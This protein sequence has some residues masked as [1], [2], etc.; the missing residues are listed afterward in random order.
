MAKLQLFRPTFIENN[1]PIA[2]RPSQFARNACI[3]PA[4][5]L[6]CM[7][8]IKEKIMCVIVSASGK[9]KACVSVLHSDIICY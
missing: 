7:R 2:A 5:R 6:E 1:A 4:F 9:G 8:T 3:P